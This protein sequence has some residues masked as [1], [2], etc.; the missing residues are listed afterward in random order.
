MHD[1]PDQEPRAKA[2]PQRGLAMPIAAALA[3]KAA[4]LLVLYLMFFAPPSHSVA[5][6]DR[7]G[8]LGLNR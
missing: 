6:A 8:F 5:P 1:A 2:G 7:G 4:A 3:L